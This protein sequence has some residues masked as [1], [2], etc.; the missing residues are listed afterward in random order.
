MYRRQLRRGLCNSKLQKLIDLQDHYS[1]QLFDQTLGTITL[2]F[3]KQ[4][5]N[6]Y[7]FISKLSEP[8]KLRKKVKNFPIVALKTLKRKKSILSPQK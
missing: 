2:S 4:Q 7:V 5:R 3:K 1:R 6:L 8:L